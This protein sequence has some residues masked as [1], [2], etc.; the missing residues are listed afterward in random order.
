MGKQRGGKKDRA[1]LKKN[2]QARV[3]R[4][5][6]T[7]RFHETDGSAL[8]DVVNVE[9]VSGK[10]EL[11]RRR[12]MATPT[13]GQLKNSDGD[14]TPFVS[15]TVIKIHGLNCRV[16]GDDQ[17]EYVCA[18]RRVL[19]SIDTE[20]RQLIAAGD[21]VVVRIERGLDGIVERVEPRTAGVLSRTSK[22]RRHVLAANVQRMLIVASVAEPVLKPHLIDRFLLTAE[23]CSIEPI[24]CLNKV[25]LVDAADL[26]KVVGVFSQLGYRVL[27]TSAAT[28]QGIRYLRAV[29][30][31]HQTVITGKAVWGKAVC[32]MWSNQS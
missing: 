30:K 19:K 18:I 23:Q 3:R 25:D 9:R 6:L 22:G 13:E 15:G 4:D 17:R 31:N 20:E 21:R 11:T 26:Q 14:E 16:R 10:G 27:L 8:D 32:S 28:G 2:H 7:R 29:L 24:I 1:A 12:T 5:D